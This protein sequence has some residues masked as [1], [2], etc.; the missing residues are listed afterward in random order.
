MIRLE[1]MQQEYDVDNFGFTRAILYD[2]VGRGYDKILELNE[3]EIIL[4]SAKSTKKTRNGLT[5]ML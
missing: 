5:I 4:K 2:V 3:A 1:E